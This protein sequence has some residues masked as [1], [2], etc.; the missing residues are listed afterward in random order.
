MLA[1]VFALLHV[2]APPVDPLDWP[3]WRGPEMNGVSREKGLP[4][5]WSQRGE[6]LLWKNP[7][8]GGRSTPVVLGGKLYSLVGHKPGQPDEAEKVICLDAATGEK[9]WEHIAPVFLSD[10]PGERIGWASVAADPDTGNVYALG[11]SGVL[12][13]LDGEAGKLRWSRSLTE[14]HGTLNTYGGRINFPIVFED[15]VIVSGVMV[16]WG[17][18][19]VPNHR[20]MALDK[21]TGEPRWFNGSKDRPPDTTYS[22]PVLGVFNGQRLF[23]VA[24][25]DGYLYAMQPR[26]G[27][28]VWSYQLSRRGVNCTPLI[29]GDKIVACQSEE[30]PGETSMG[31]VA[32]IDGT[33]FGDVTKSLA[34]WRNK[35]QM[36][37]R[38]TPLPVG[39]RLFCIDDGGAVIVLDQATGARQPGTLKLGTFQRCSPLYADGKIYTCDVNGKWST[40]TMEGGKPKVVFQT[41]LRG[42]SSGSTEV[43]SSP[44][45]SHG[46]LYV[47]TLD[48]LSCIGTKG[49][50]PAPDPTPPAAEETPAGNDTD[51]ATVV[52]SP[53][54]A[55][56]KPGETA[57]FKVRLYNKLGQPAPDQAAAFSVARMETAPDKGALKIVATTDPTIGAVDAAGT[58]TAGAEAGFR[59]A[60][61][62]AKIG[63][64][65]GFARV[66]IVPPLPWKFDF[67][68][69]TVPITW[70]GVRYRHVVRPLDGVPTMVKITTIPLGTRSQGWIGPTDLHDY[71][72]QADFRGART[73]KKMP[74]FGLIAQ[75]YRLECLGAPREDGRQRLQIRTWYPSATRARQAIPFDWKPDTWYTMK[76]RAESAADK[77]TVRG[78]LWERGQ[79][80]PAEWQITLEDPAANRNG[81]PGLFGDAG[82]AELFIQNLAVTPN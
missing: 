35:E 13:C 12:Q 38:A 77:T 29:L 6:N 53:A 64:L 24:A 76:F 27:K 63:G 45:V 18:K 47:Q 43:H 68:D 65:E 17:D 71:T 44:I 74:D 37:G 25:G 10:V 52:V 72:I 55:M 21:R 56:V 39:D 32:M 3:Y 78:K 4:E 9:K 30:N 5:R 42:D 34:K 41:K 16:G 1:L 73:N 11:S 66:R 7:D 81:S 19:A 8:A 15:L 22:A 33:G 60:V 59:A 82:N 75:R 67:A 23:V 36:V 2:A 50:R 69:K 40:L 57:A 61:L 31:S 79:P 20:W 70:T 62:T 46:R 51:P 80:E 14:E 54:E 49:E 26:T 48:C 58:F 28:I